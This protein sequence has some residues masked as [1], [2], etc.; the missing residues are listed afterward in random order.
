M[1]T[2]LGEDAASAT[3]LM[4]WY[5]LAT[6]PILE[7]TRQRGYLEAEAAAEELIDRRGLEWGKDEIV[8]AIHRY[9]PEVP[10]DLEAAREAFT[11]AEVK[12]RRG[13]TR[14]VAAGAARSDE[15]VL[16]AL[17]LGH[18]GTV[19][20]FHGKRA[21]EA[22]I[23]AEAEEDLAVSIETPI[24]QISVTFPEEAATVHALTLWLTIS[25]RE[26]VSV[27]TAS[28][29]R[30]DWSVFVPSA[31]LAEAMAVLEDLGVPLADE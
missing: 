28:Y 16:S 21:V 9:D 31:D 22:I 13:L 12:T 18:E 30:S 29:A 5:H 20:R 3:D 23:D 6:D 24:A 25:M 26:T 4:V 15:R 8:S 11:S 10:I 14:V 2:E 27:T 17:P 7:G 1:T 19:H